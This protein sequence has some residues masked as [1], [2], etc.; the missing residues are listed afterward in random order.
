MARCRWGKNVRV[1]IFVVLVEKTNYINVTTDIT[2]ILSGFCYHLQSSG[3]LK[4]GT[5]N[6]VSTFQVLISPLVTDIKCINKNVRLFCVQKYRPR[7]PYDVTNT[8]VASQTSALLLPL[9]QCT[10]AYL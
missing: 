5:G 6:I 9:R 2:H 8:L 10:C 4:T 3:A 7:P 1:G